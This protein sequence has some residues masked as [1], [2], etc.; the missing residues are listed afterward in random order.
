MRSW[1]TDYTYDGTFA[2]WQSEK[3]METNG[4]CDNPDVVT[5]WTDFHLT[6]GS[7]CRNAGTDV[8]LTEDYAGNTVPQGAGFD[9]GAYEYVEGLT[10][11]PLTGAG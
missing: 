5:S 7:P 11:L 10:T 2:E 1:V 6:A 9:M 4:I 3:S 8:G